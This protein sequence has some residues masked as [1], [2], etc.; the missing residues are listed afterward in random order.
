VFTV[1]ITELFVAS[2]MDN[3][4]LEKLVTYKVCHVRTGRGDDG[5]ARV[6][7]RCL[8]AAAGAMLAGEALGI[9]QQREGL[10]EAIRMLRMARRFAIKART[11]TVNQLRSVPDTAPEEL[12][13]PLRALSPQ[14]LVARTQRWRPGAP[15][16][17]LAAARVTLKLLAERWA[18]LSAE[19]V[20]LDAHVAPLLAA[21]APRLLATHGVGPDTAATLLLCR[22]SRSPVSRSRIRCWRS[23]P[24]TRTRSQ[25]TTRPHVHNRRVQLGPIYF[26]QRPAL[27]GRQLG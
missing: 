11:Q 17:P 6:T 2:I 4:S 7:A 18:A 10:V 8:E 19:P 20:Q 22:T 5:T 24:K 1:A 21:A 13:E 12:S 15:T 23:A 27:L 14:A 26:V 25:C 3:V 9:P 16:D